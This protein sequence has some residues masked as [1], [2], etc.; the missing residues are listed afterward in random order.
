[1]IVELVPVI[2]IGY[3]NQ[4]IEVPD[5]ITHYPFW[6]H[7][8]IWDKYHAESYIKAGFK[9]AMKPY[10]PGLSFYLFD[11]ISDNNL[12]KLMKDHIGDFGNDSCSF[13]G[14]YVLCINNQAVFYPQCCGLLSDIR[15]W[16]EL[17]MGNTNAYYEGHPAPVVSFN[18]DKIILDFMLDENEPFVPPVNAPII[19]IDRD[20]LKTAITNVKDKLSLFGKR[21]K[22]I[23]NQED[24]AISNIDTVLIWNS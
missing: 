15:Y 8:E 17:S 13:F 6:K 11:S 1:M 2:D 19:Q 7:A 3:N 23:A 9:D 18:A 16:E 5:L 22:K 24:L 10:L 12:S 4:G 20:A 21:L 14:G